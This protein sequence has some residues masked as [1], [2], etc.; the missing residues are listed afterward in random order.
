[1]SDKPTKRSSIA[2]NWLNFF[3]ADVSDGV[4]P[5]L[6]VYLATNLHWKSGQIG[7]AIAATTF[8]MVIAQGPAGYIV[9]KIRRKRLP[10][11]IASLISGVVAFCYPFYQS[12]L[13]IIISQVVLGLS[14]SFYIPT[15]VAL[16]S[17]MSGKGEFDRTISKNQSFNHAGNVASAVFTGVVARFTNNAG[18]FYVMMAL[19]VMCTVSASFIAQK[20]VED[21]QPKAENAQEKEDKKG[22][23]KQLWSNKPFLIF[24][25]LTVIFYFSN[26]ALLPLVA[27]EITKTAKGNSTLYLSACIIIAQ[28]VM[29]PTVYICGKQAGKGRKKLLMIAFM[30]LAARA[31]IYAFTDKTWHL[32]VLQVMDGM[33]AGVFSVV[34]IMVVD[35]LMGNS[36]VASFAQGLLATSLSLGS[37]LSNLSA[38]FIVDAA[39]FK[40]GFIFL[41]ALALGALFLLWKVMPETKKA[42]D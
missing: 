13:P 34:A 26:G 36:D 6:A 15:L 5:F 19:A 17:V 30:L 41:C 27:Q 12:F 10:I 29:I 14:A 4:G 18:I 21:K 1:M 33:A 31:F 3:A 28:L 2:L 32:L 40:I 25:L 23:I 20:D 39:G 24:L 11:I 37:T 9:D 38:G 7:M 8:S 16:A 42:T 22:F 35:D